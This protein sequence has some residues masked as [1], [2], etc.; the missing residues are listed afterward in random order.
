MG[1]KAFIQDVKE[2]LDLDDFSETKKKKAIKKLLKKLEKRKDL[3]KQR[4]AVA[5][6]DEEKAEIQEELKIIKY[7]IK[8]GNKLLEKLRKDK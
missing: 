3:V 8:K 1:I 4:L 5:L 7:Q 2:F 6:N